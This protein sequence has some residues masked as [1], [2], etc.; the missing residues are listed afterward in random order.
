MV[1]IAVMT[2]RTVPHGKVFNLFGSCV[3]QVCL[4]RNALTF[5]IENEQPTDIEAFCWSVTEYILNSHDGEPSTRRETT[6][7]IRRFLKWCQAN[8]ISDVSAIS[9]A[10][11]EGF[12]YWPVVLGG[13]PRKPGSSTKRNRLASLRRAYKTSRIIGYEL[14]DP[15]IDVLVVFDHAINT[16]YCTDDDIEKLRNAT[17]VEL[18]K[19]TYASIWALAEAGATNSEIKDV[20]VCDVNLEEGVVHLAGNAR[21]DERINTLTELGLNVLAQRIRGLNPTDYLIL[22]TEGGKCSEATISQIFRHITSYANVGSKGFN[23]NSVRAWR[24]RKIFDETGRIQDA[25]RFLGNRSLD[26]TALLI[27]LEWRESA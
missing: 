11:I 3:C 27:G 25:A 19:T 4:L 20:R 5:V 14:I 10:D 6:L 22:N 15:T 17:P 21:V 26:S 8:G 18:F 24:A 7:H 12:V 16:N 13:K 23:I 2:H 1:F 9:Q